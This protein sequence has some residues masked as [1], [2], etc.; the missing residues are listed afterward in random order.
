MKFSWISL[1]YFINLNNITINKLTE[2]LTIKGFEIDQIYYDTT[3]KDYI[4]DI[5]ITANRQDT[6]S[7][8]GI[9]T[10]LSF[11]LNKTIKKHN[12][13]LTYKINNNNFINEKTLKYFLNIKINKIINIQ[14]YS[15]P[16]WLKN[17]LKVHEIESKNLIIDIQRYIKIKWGH[18]ILFFNFDNFDHAEDF[19]NS[20]TTSDIY[21]EQNNQS[22]TIFYNT[23]LLIQVSKN[24]TKV[25]DNL[26]Y[27][28][29]PFSILSCSYLYNTMYLPR[30]KNIYNT[31]DN[32]QGYY[33]ALQLL[34]T[35]GKA[36]ISK[37]YSYENNIINKYCLKI[38][39]NFI[40]KTLGPINNKKSKYLKVNT[41]IQILKQLNL[42]PQYN[43]Y[44]KN[45]NI[46]VPQYRYDDLYRKIDIIEE[47]GRIYGY[48]NF[49]DNIKY[50]NNTGNLSKQY[51]I[52]KYIRQ[53]FR[54][55]GLHE[56]INSSLNKCTFNTYNEIQKL[57]MINIHN[58]LLDDQSK[59]RDNL[60]D[61]LIKNKIYNYKQKN[62][63]TEIFE[64]GK[65]FKKYLTKNQTEEIIG[66]AGILANKNFIKKSWDKKHSHLNWFH[67]KGLLEQ[68]FEKIQLNIKWH[69]LNTL[70]KQEV[71]SLS[72]NNFEIKH[73][74]CI[75]DTINKRLIGLM[76][77]VQKTIHNKLPQYESI[78]I[79]ELNINEIIQ[80]YNK[81]WHLS[82]IFSDYSI[83]PSVIRD[84]S[85]KIQKNV[86]I[87]S[88]KNFIYNLNTNFI[89]EVEIFNQYIDTITNKKC[90]GIR[91]I[92]NSKNKTLNKNDLK[93]IDK[94]IERIYK[95]Y[96]NK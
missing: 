14:T 33:E 49:L 5:G 70:N 21:I 78:N 54:D 69:N 89:Q 65:I 35:F 43:N 41:I 46:I 2:L 13:I 87:T 29:Q 75:R 72:L 53:Y 22:E 92:Y 11:I 96:S 47:I 6:F 74:V 88:I 84:L 10:E 38:N 91:I 85:L 76:G 58:P 44:T 3:F 1:N 4:L 63:N 37:S 90:I 42:R 94:D 8:F 28:G 77:P 51:Q 26:Q 73:T 59:L 95:A 40:Q 7:V 19:N 20:K 18:D 31:R 50:L 36:Y 12:P 56:A 30:I 66:I 62:N 60:I 83:Y 39:K 71:E 15:S 82:Y 52:I 16:L 86:N 80:C 27:K 32:M 48:E 93:S 45:F 81:Q 64:I 17:Y 25:N 24:N 9:A 57:S 79:F 61:N 23:N 34:A 68:F 55:I 67:A